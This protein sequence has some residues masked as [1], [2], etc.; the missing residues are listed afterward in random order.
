MRSLSPLVL[1]TLATLLVLSPVQ[2]EMVEGSVRPSKEVVLNAPLPSIL[3]KIEVAEGDRIEKDEPLAFMDDGLQQVAVRAAQLEAESD[4]AV[5]NAKLVLEDA[6]IQLGQIKESNKKGAASEWEVRK[7]SLQVEV[8]TAKL[9]QANEQQELARVNL[10]LERAR[11][12]RYAVL[13][14]FTGR[15]LRIEAEAG[16]SLTQQDP[17][18][19]LVA[20]NPLE[21][22]FHLPASAYGT[23]ELNERYGLIR[24]QNEGPPI[25]AKLISIDPVID[26]A[27][28]TFRV[29]LEI[30]NA[31]EL[32]PSGFSVFLKLADR[33]TPENDQ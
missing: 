18:L 33:E 14:P 26:P 3:S 8:E 11:L 5:E 27:S 15:V 4:T 13:A 30:D 22:E 24:K 25:A 16:A 10:E 7:A 9:K 1:S 31:D 32:M 17:I 19:S 2:A 29:V 20:L 28:Q 12:K 6:Q 21:A 23:L